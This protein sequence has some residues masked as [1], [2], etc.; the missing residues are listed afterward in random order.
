MRSLAKK[1]SLQGPSTSLNLTPMID[2]M[3]IM[4]VFLIKSY[5]ADPAYLTP[6]QGIELSSTSSENAA[7]DDAVVIVGK[8]GVLVEGKTVITFKQ[9]RADRAYFTQDYSAPLRTALE[10]MKKAG[11][12]G[13]NHSVILQ[14]DKGVAFEF[15]KPVLRTLGVA[16]FTD[17]KFAG[18]YAN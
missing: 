12:K 14:A 9:G 11:A 1:H 13:E 4:L 3:V 15:L 8:D 5:S 7:P 10:K 17:I 18:V 6:T 16:G 2:M